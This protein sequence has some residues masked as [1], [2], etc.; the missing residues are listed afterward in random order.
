MGSTIRVSTSA[1]SAPGQ[2][3]ITSTM[4]TRIC[5][6]SSRGV[7][8]RA[9]APRP[10]EAAMRSGVSLLSRKAWATLPAN[11]TFM[12]LSPILGVVRAPRTGSLRG[13][14]RLRSQPVARSRERRPR[15]RRDRG[16][17]ARPAPTPARISTVSPSRAPTATQRSRALPSLTTKTPVRPPRSNTAAAGTLIQG[18]ATTP[19]TSSRAKRPERRPEAPGR[20]AFTSKRCVVGSPEGE[21]ATTVA[22]S[23]AG[24]AVHHRLDLRAGPQGRRDLGLD[25]G[26][27]LEAALA[28]DLD[29]GHAGVDHV[30]DVHPARRP[31]ARR[32]GRGARRRR[33]CPW[34]R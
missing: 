29:E 15:V 16:R 21:T 20:S 11:P 18:S 27:Q 4:G 9:R 30:A 25:R 8:R 24:L 26:P 13:V 3:T 2:A 12:M 23:G 28:L 10:R 17:R 31:L 6:S 32:R 19:G 5:G 1:G 22:V 33:G 14:I 7:A 34:P